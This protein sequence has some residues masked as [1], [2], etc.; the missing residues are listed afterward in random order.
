MG[1][2]WETRARHTHGAH[3]EDTCKTYTWETRARHI[4]GRHVQD[5]HMEDTC[6]RHT[7]ETRAREWFVL[8]SLDGK[9]GLFEESVFLS[10]DAKPQP[11]PIHLHTHLPNKWN[12][13]YYI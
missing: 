7:W 9:P 13:M 10:K 2:A 4:H 1:H 5:T 3:M 11:H 8:L 6:K 12:Y